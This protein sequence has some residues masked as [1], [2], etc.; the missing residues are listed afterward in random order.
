[1]CQLEKRAQGVWQSVGRTSGAAADGV[2]PRCSSPSRSRV[3]C[4]AGHAQHAP[5]SL[6]RGGC[7]S[8]EEGELVDAWNFTHECG[9]SGCSQELI[10]LIS[11]PYTMSNYMF[12]CSPTAPQL[13]HTKC[14]AAPCNGPLYILPFYILEFPCGICEAAS[15]YIGVSRVAFRGHR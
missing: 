8:K 12:T 9:S 14:V 10:L 5:G 4:G 15:I 6:G 1:M 11:F 3:S 2:G 7:M 13:E